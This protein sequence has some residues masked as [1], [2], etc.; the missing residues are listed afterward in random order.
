MAEQ[1]CTWLHLSDLH[2]RESTSWD[3]DIVLKGLV[4]DVEERITAEHLQPDL[5]FVTGD[6]AHSGRASEY[7]LAGRFFDRLLTATGLGKDCLF[8]VPGNHDVNRG[9]ITQGTESIVK[10]LN[11]RGKLNKHFETP[12]DRKAVFKKLTGYADFVNMYM[13]GHLCIDDEHYYY[14]ECRDI[15]GKRV[16]VLGLNSVWLSMSDQDRNQLALG[17]RQVRSA[18]S[19]AQG[20]DLRIALLHHPLDWLYDF[21]QEN[22]GTL[23]QSNCDFILHGHMHR[24]GVLSLKDPESEAMIV[25]AGACYNTRESANSYNI[26]RLDATVGRGVVYLRRYSD[27]RGGFWATDTT[28]YR[29]ASG[30]QYG[31]HLSSNFSPSI[32]GSVTAK[33]ESSAFS[34]SWPIAPVHLELKIYLHSR[35]YVLDFEPRNLLPPL[36]DIPLAQLPSN[37]SID[38]VAARIAQRVLQEH[39]NEKWQQIAAQGGRLSVKIPDDMWFKSRE[40]ELQ[41]ELVKRLLGTYVTFP[42]IEPQPPEENAVPPRPSTPSIVEL[43]DKYNIAAIRSL[44]EA[45]FIAED[46]RRLCQEHSDLR[47]VNRKFA[48]KF[49]IEDM[50]YEV[51]EYCRTRDLFPR[52]LSA[53][54]RVRGRQFQS[55]QSQIYGSSGASDYAGGEG[56]PPGT[57]T[58]STSPDAQSGPSIQEQIRLTFEQGLKYLDDS[59]WENAVDKFED[60]LFL[61]PDHQEVRKLL[62]SA[63]QKL[64]EERKVKSIY[65]RVD[66]L[67]A[68]A[69][70]YMESEKW[71]DAEGL[72]RD[73][74][75]LKPDL[76]DVQQ[77]LQIVKEKLAEQRQEQRKIRELEFNYDRA[78]KHL[79]KRE[80]DRAIWFLRRV[81]ELDKGY[82][83]AQ[84][85]LLR[86]TR[87][88]QL[89]LWYKAAEQAI[90]A[91]NWEEVIRLLDLIGFDEADYP[92]VEKKRDYAERQKKLGSL[93]HNALGDMNAERWEMAVKRLD[94]ILAVDTHYRES[95]LAR[96]YALARIA[97]E[98]EEWDQALEQFSAV[99]HIDA[100]YRSAST[101]FDQARKQAQLHDLYSRGK[102]YLQSEDWRQAQAA[103]DQIGTIDPHYKDA[104]ELAKQVSDAGRLAEMYDRAIRYFNLS[105]WAEAIK[106]L[107]EILEECPE[108]HDAVDKRVIAEKEKLLID[109]YMQ[110]LKESDEGRWAEAITTF[111]HIVHV[112]PNY[113]DAA[114]RLADVRKKEQL[115][116]LY[117]QGEQ[118]F[119]EERWAEAI[120]PLDQV[121]EQDHS[122]RRASVMLAEAKKQWQLAMFYQ[123]GLR[124]FQEKRW[125]QAISSFEE[126]VAKDP[127]YKDNDA[128]TKLKQSR[129]ELE[130]ARIY[131][132]AQKAETR[133][134]WTQ[135]S[136]FLSK[137]PR[138]YR[139]GAVV[140]IAKEA[141]KQHHLAQLYTQARQFY[142]SQEWSRAVPL[143]DRVLEQDPDYHDADQMVKAA[144]REIELNQ[145]YQAGID[146]FQ[147]KNWDLAIR[148]LEHVVDTAPYYLDALARLSEARQAKKLADLYS[149]GQEHLGKAEWSLA[150]AN[151]EEIVRIQPRYEQAERLL[152][153]ARKQEKLGK[154]YQEATTSIKD[155][156]WKDAAAVLRRI[157]AEGGY[158]DAD[159]QL[160]RADLEI[161]LAEAYELGCHYMQ[162]QRWTEAIEQ[163]EKIQAERSDY[164][165][166]AEKLTETRKEKELAELWA[167][168]E[169]L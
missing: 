41:V 44:I 19:L 9:D 118:A 94:E 89:D 49:S 82:R 144:R 47:P 84:D 45:A 141:E 142:N 17:E 91:G 145:D 11:N 153:T 23:L 66:A 119:Q 37:L 27:L 148:Y 150:V 57:P 130:W 33:R 83:D 137:L 3:T 67:Y 122:Y 113:R 134:E 98:K 1:T 126:V 139:D 93:Y 58:S 103:F 129:Q 14:V 18:I 75:G 15:A 12:L 111:E 42:T 2:F 50:S 151:L 163:L 64:E 159:A 76:L 87:D 59:D 167:E 160:E 31:F 110:G 149:S 133:K 61:D 53:I 78:S 115:V 96:R 24:I 104:V 95:A 101:Y 162:L 79:E 71:Q 124:L 20:A 39:G 88:Q 68:R 38:E 29:N 7:E 22:I 123:E 69:K 114:K 155:G 30:G 21:D 4:E 127:S 143:L 147:V 81:I 32:T 60:V 112:E 48:P 51:T 140:R 116:E 117:N 63:K 164:L 106:Y 16:A 72:L 13:A 102:S 34:P 97:M 100:N 46:F 109:L 165:D 55:F 56:E 138:E 6:I 154:W 128:T 131:Q 135:V 26:V 121:V 74:V 43:S 80:W 77:Q 120:D 168:L 125:E 146:A 132:D 108:Y 70:L 90:E 105:E 156:K 10:G 169:S 73:I 25:G 92:D 166:V 5:I 40:A 62:E 136:D 152:A 54:E 161:E 8:L 86:A 157:I 36:T 99:V 65:E 158:L 28:S 35:H 85:K 52:L 107:N